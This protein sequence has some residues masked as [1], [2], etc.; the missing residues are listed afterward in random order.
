MSV[1]FPLFSKFYISS[2]NSLKM[3]FN[4]S[5]KFI[6]IIAVPIGVG[7]TILSS[8]IIIF[9]F[10]NEYAPSGSVLR[11]LIWASVL[12]FINMIPATLLNSTNKQKELMTFTAIGAFVNLLMNY[13]LIPS[14][15]YEGAGIA[16]V[17]T[18]F[19]VGLL[20]IYY[21]QKRQDVLVPFWDTVYRSLISAITMGIYIS[22]FKSI[23]LMFLIPLA[24]IMYFV[25]LSIMS[26]IGK[27]DLQLLNQ[28]WD[29]KNG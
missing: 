25:S 8:E 2:K 27:D 1:M 20:M 4:K 15:S 5:L 12:S 22:I 29:D 18:E 23:P 3:S 10:G 7:T 9:I 16:T 6:T 11:I 17:I 28:V 13:L 19:T 24:S 26:G 21:I 14:F